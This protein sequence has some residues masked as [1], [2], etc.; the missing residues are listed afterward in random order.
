VCTG[1]YVDWKARKRNFYQS[2][3]EPSLHVGPILSPFAVTN[4]SLVVVLY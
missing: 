2:G 3:A 1:F 4:T